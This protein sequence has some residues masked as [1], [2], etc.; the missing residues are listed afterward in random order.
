MTK[1]DAIIQTRNRAER[2]LAISD[3]AF[4]LAMR[5]CSHLYTNPKVTLDAPFPLPWSKVSLWCG[6]QEREAYSR[7]NEL[8]N[9]NYLKRDG[10]RGC[11]PIQN[12]FLVFNSTLQGGIDSI[13]K[14]G[15]DSIRKGGINSTQEGG[16]HIS[17]SFQEEKI[18]VKREENGSLRSKGTKWE[19]N[20]SLRS[21]E[22]NDGDL[23]GKT[24]SSE[25]RNRMAAELA[26]LRSTLTKT[27]SAAFPACPANAPARKTTLKDKLAKLTKK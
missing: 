1:K 27:H 3:G 23:N 11:P 25:Q 13:R 18:K 10:L 22:K 8:V 20:G 14:G 19:V 12:Y 24:L 4:R 5:L 26:C 15:I 16:H 6:C 2:D 9:K 7:I 21:T 17:N